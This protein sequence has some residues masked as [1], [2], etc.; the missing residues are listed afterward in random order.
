[1]PKHQKR[2]NEVFRITGFLA[3]GHPIVRHIGELYPGQPLHA[4]DYIAKYAEIDI[5]V[6]LA[7]LGEKALLAIHKTA[8]GRELPPGR[9]RCTTVK[10][11][12]DLQ[13][14]AAL[15]AAKEMYI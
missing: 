11:T 4:T 15:K 7:D 14:N 3:S 9:Q 6:D 12:R 13:Y 8:K 5:T 10:R 1:M 2:I